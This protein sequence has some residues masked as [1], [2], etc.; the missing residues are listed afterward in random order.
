MN[1]SPRLGPLAATLGLATTC[2][3]AAPAY[4]EPARL[5]EIGV[6][7]YP[8]AWPEDQWSR[9]I[10]NI[11]SMG[12]EH[13]HVGEFAWT[14]L[15]P[16]ESRFAFE[17]LERVVKLS[18]DQGLKV[19]LC[20]PSA[21]PPVWLVRRHPEVLMI[22]ARDRRMNHGSRQHACWSVDLYRQYVDKIVT[23][24][25]KRFGQNPAVEGWQL[26]NEIS[27]YG[28]QYCYCPASQ[29]K[30]RAW[31]QARYGTIAQLNR[32]WGNAFWSQMYQT[33]DQIDEPNPEELVQQV[34]PHAQLDLQRW[35]AEEVADYLRFQ[36]EA[37]RRHVR[38]QWITHNFDNLYSRA[39]V[40]PSLSSRDLDLMSFTRYL[41]HGEPGEGPLGFR[42]GD[43]AAL[44]FMGDFLR[45]TGRP[46]G[47][48]ELQPGQV[49][50]GDVN[51]QPLPGA[52]RM[53]IL[54]VFV[55]GSQV[56]SSYRYRQPLSGGELYHNAMVTTDGVTPARGGKEYAQAIKDVQLLRERYRPGAKEPAGY[57]ARRTA[58]LYDYEN[59]WDIDNHRQTRRW[60]T[61]AHVLKHYKALKRLGCPVDVGEDLELGR[62]PFAVAPAYQLVDETLVR[63]WT[64]YVK[65]GG[66]LVLSCRTG[67]KDRRGHLW[68]GPWAAPMRDLIGAA[69]DFYDTLPA[70]LTGRVRRGDAAYE[71]ATWGEIL[72]P[73]DGTR[74]LAR[75]ADQ[76]YAERPAAVSRRLGKGTVTYVGVDTLAGDLEH[77]LL[78]GVFAEAG[79]AVEAFDS[80]F[81]VDWRDGFW[82]ATNFTER[83]QRAPVPPGARLLI[84]ERQVPPA[85]VAVWV[86]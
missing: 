71:W 3:L 49:N 14:Q 2:A 48:T 25:A 30:F 41:V 79:V 37:L 62:Y 33:F 22:D 84:G 68:E 1:C 65:G 50:W 45:G 28:R 86:E 78:R 20:T 55:Q 32:D 42:L 7:Y 75:Y 57:A 64:E 19:I 67:H 82:V 11:R 46:W 10:A 40:D 54:R 51:P 53:W 77:D 47:L 6:Y 66:H 12:F 21:A 26:D 23:E 35:Q 63:R 56:V 27:H 52:I 9:D 83:P 76:F 43:G 58:L 60:D 38:G 18:A 24:M 16:E 69:V 36:T 39:E 8:E 85:G 34:N 70:S 61:H 81:F 59:R 4:F 5:M 13:V 72:A 15:E 17:W 80:Q 29:A 31:L 44:S 74:V 73:A